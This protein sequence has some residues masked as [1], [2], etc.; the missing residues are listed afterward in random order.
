MTEQGR[1]AA[2]TVSRRYERMTLACRSIRRCDQIISADSLCGKTC[3][4]ARVVEDASA[5]VG[6]GACEDRPAI[7]QRTCAAQEF[8]EGVDIWLVRHWGTVSGV[9]KP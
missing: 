5:E 1:C 9:D 7:I 4:A 2:E 8:A 3:C 6:F